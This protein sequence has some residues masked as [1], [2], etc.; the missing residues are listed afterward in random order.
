LVHTNKDV[1]DRFQALYEGLMA[2]DGFGE[3]RLEMRILKR[4]QKEILIHCGKQYRF[5]V[6]YRPANPL[7]WE[8]RLERRR[9]TLAIDFP[10]RRRRR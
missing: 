9:Q 6:D 8:A 1:L 4:G 3:M 10:E 7:A 2:H 5:V